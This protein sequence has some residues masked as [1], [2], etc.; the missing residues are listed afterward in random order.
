MALVNLQ[1][2]VDPERELEFKQLMEEHECSTKQAFLE[3]LMERFKNPKTYPV[4]KD[5]P[6]TLAALTQARADIDKLTEA[7]LDAAGELATQAIDGKEWREIQANFKPYLLV[8]KKEGAV[9]SYAELFGLMLQVLQGH[10]R[11]ILEPADHAYLKSLE[12]ANE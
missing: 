1:I 2:K 8:L 3:L 4:V 12:G 5:T 7:A 6:E 9:N 11:F 10:R